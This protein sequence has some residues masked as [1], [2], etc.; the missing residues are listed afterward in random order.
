M[1]VTIMETWLDSNS[2]DLNWISLVTHDGLSGTESQ[3]EV[4]ES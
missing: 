4:L 3:L 1:S 2:W